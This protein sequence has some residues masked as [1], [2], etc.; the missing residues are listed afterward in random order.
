VHLN[1]KKKLETEILNFIDRY[2]L[3]E[4]GDKLLL[5]L[6]GGP[7]SVFAFHFLLK[8]QR[9]FKLELACIHVNHLL[10]GQESDEDEKFVGELCKS[11]GIKLYLRTSDTKQY[12]RE[13][14]Y[15]IEEAARILRYSEFSSVRQKTGCN[16]IVT[17]HNCN[18]NT[19]TV[20]MNTINGTGLSG[21]SGIPVKRGHIIRP[22]LP[23]VKNEILE[24]LESQNIGYRKD[25][26]NYSSD[27]Q[28]NYLRINIIPEL[29][30]HL[31]PSLQK[32]ILNTS[33]NLQ[34]AVN[35]LNGIVDSI[36][37]KSVI[38][39]KNGIELLPD[40]SELDNE[41]LFGEVI[42]KISSEYLNIEFNRKLADQILS[43][44]SA[45]TGRHLDLEK[46]WQVI[47]E[48]D[49]LRFYRDNKITG[50]SEVTL[51]PGEVA[52]LCGVKVGCEY[53][54]GDPELTESNNNTEII[55]ADKLD[56]I[57]ILRKWKN[58]DKFQPLGMKGRKKVSDFLTE[59]KVPA[60]DKNNIL[61][62]TNNETIVWVVGL[63]ISEKFKF[64][65]KSKK[66]I[67]LWTK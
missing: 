20:F 22:F 41:Y 58:G 61:V 32:S 65:G 38:E 37:K 4:Y 28:R 45:Q 67:K 14:N 34:T 19:E 15:S 52:D 36:M 54:D 16:K 39:R 26:S 25:S 35:Y 2:K 53:I 47:R 64:T 1:S 23:A 49:S 6:S 30:N 56:D 5:G 3:I 11:R 50:E 66:V 44:K 60:S 33:L 27:F 18:D 46:G 8:Y 48:R 31:N 24:F 63:R 7:D 13:K 29:E 17:A 55:S 62:L 21:F 57:F 59:Q 12:S 43:L 51:K 42:K 10:R 9:R 40:N